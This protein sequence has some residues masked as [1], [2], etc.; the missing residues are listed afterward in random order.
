MVTLWLLKGLLFFLTSV[1]G[2]LLSYVCLSLLLFSRCA[3]G[4]TPV[5]AA[6]YAASPEVMS[7]LIDAGGD[8]RLHDND[9][10]S[11][12]D[13]ALKHM[14]K[15]KARAMICYI[16]ELYQRV[17]ETSEDGDSQPASPQT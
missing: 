2:L 16:E 11:V 5:H 4:S 14:D 12:K 15:K 17:M 8:L 10:R 9:G 7:L 1:S 3:D 13:W 6:C